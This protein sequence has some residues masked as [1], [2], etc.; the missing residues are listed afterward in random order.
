MRNPDET[1]IGRVLITLGLIIVVIYFIFGQNISIKNIFFPDEP[2]L[3][4]VESYTNQPEWFV[5]P[6][7]YD[8]QLFKIEGSNISNWLAPV[9]LLISV[10]NK[11]KNSVEDT[12]HDDLINCT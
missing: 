7:I 3:I 5:S 11:G 1:Q 12:I 9:P 6:A 8:P 4:V 10:I 2:D